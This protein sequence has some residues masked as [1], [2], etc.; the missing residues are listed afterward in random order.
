MPFLSSHLEMQLM[1]PPRSSC[2][3]QLRRALAVGSLFLGLAASASAQGTDSCTT[4]QVVAGFGSFAFDNSAAAAGNDFVPA[5]APIGRDVWFTWTAASSGSTTVATCGG[6]GLDSVMAVYNGNT[7]PGAAELACSDDACGAQSSVTF[8]ATSGNSYVIQI[9]SY[10]TGA[11]STGTFTISGPPVP[12]VNDDCSAATAISGTGLFPF[13]TINATTGAQGQT[14]SLCLA[15]GFNAIAKDVWYNWTAPSTGIATVALCGQTSLDSKI[16]SYLGAGCPSA[17]ALACNDD[18]CSLQS[19]IQFACTA[20]QVYALQIGSYPGGSGSSGS[21]NFNITVGAPMVKLSQIYGA[22]GN[23]QSPVFN[24]YI[25][26][27]NAGP[28]AQP[29]SGWSVQYASAA[30]AFTALNTTNLPAVN[31]APGQYLLVNEATGATLVAGQTPNNPLGDASGA[32]AMSGTDMKVALVSSTAFIPTALGQPTYAAVPTLVDF[33]GCGTANWNDTAAA[34]GT[35]VATNNA[36]AITTAAASYRQTCGLTDTNSSIADWS[37]GFPAPR[38][39]ATVANTGLGV[40]GSALPLTPKAGQTVRLTATPF[41]CTTNDLAAGTTM[42]A[43]LTLI[44]GS[45]T[46]AMVDDGTGGDEVSNDGL[47]TA[48]VTVGAA[49]PTGTVNLPIKATNGASVG[50]SYISLFIEPVATP[51]NDNC[52]GAQALTINTP[53][54]GTCVGATV[55]T[56]PIVTGVT[57]GA[58]TSGMSSR[59]G[60]WYSVV[61]TGNSMSASL[62]GTLPVFDSVMIVMTGSC[63]GLTVIGVD[64]DFCA[65]L[66]ASQVTWCSQLGA[67]YYIWVAPFSTALP[68]NTFTIAVNDSGTACTGAFP[69]TLC[70]GVSGPFTE[71]EAMY[72]AA[73]NE[74]CFTNAAKFTDIPMPG[75]SATILRGTAR[76]LINTRDVDCYRFQATGS[77]PIQITIDTLGSQAQAQLVS[78]GA[79]GTCPS[80]AI[81]NTPI[82]LTRC[83]TGIQTVSANVVSGTWYAI[84][85]IGGIDIQ[86]TPAGTIFGGEMPGGTTIQYTLSVN[87]G[88][89]P[90][91]DLCANATTLSGVSVA[92]N[93]LTATNDGSSPCDASGRDVWYTVTN[94][95][96]AGFLNLDTCGSTGIDTVISVYDSC[97]GLLLGCNDDCGGTPCGATNSC[98]SVAIAAGQTLKIRVS[99]KGLVGGAFTLNWALVVPPPANDECAT[100]TVISGNGPFAYDN[101]F[102]TPTTA[103]APTSTCQTSQSK[104]IWYRWTSAGAGTVNVDTCGGPTWDSVI[105]IYTGSCGTL[106]EIACDDDTCVTPAL[107]SSLSFTAACTTTYYIRISSFGTSIGVTG[108]FNLTAPGNTDTDM[109]GTPDCIDGC[110]LDPAKIAPGICGCGVSDADTDGDGTVDCLDGCPNDANKIA[111]GI[112]GCGVSDVDTDGDGTADCLDGCPND[113]NKIAPGICGCGVSDVDT[114]GDGTADCLDGCPNDPAK[115]APG[116]CGCGVSDV[117][118]DGDGTADCFDGCPN[119]ANKIAPGQCGCGNLDTD[120]DGDGTADCNDGCPN[121]SAKTAPGQCGCGVA[122]TDSDGDGVANCIDNC[123]TVANASQAD[124]DNDG[125]GDACDNCVNISNPAQGDCDADNIGDAC[126]IASGAPDCNMNG[127]PDSCDIASATSQDANTNGIPDECEL[128]GGTPFCFG[129]SGCP[130]GNN[131][132]PGMGQGCMNST[133]QGAKLLGS[134][135]TQ[136][137]NDNLVLTCTQLPIPGVPPGFVQFFQGTASTSIPFNDGKRCVTGTLVRLATKAHATGASS[138]P[139]LGDL[140]IHQKGFVPPAGGVRYYQAWYRNAIGP[141]GTGSNLSNGVSVIWAP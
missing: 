18:T 139:Q 92:G 44:G 66:N 83:A 37:N 71:K 58:F 61:G 103:T 138:Y 125:V 94:G 47:Y 70:T 69:V 38:N 67:T 59:K 78:L 76:G 111:P 12:P 16:A 74:G 105:T 114:D 40:I 13:T 96:D 82:F 17:S 81:A 25:E 64:D 137:S 46:Q 101:R 10:N 20:G 129:D 53:T 141:C 97:G 52:Y 30:G 112:C 72:G 26:I 126:E 136:V 35:N 63:D 5:C 106:T 6:T 102:A 80:T 75:S 132:I 43:D 4:P 14:E 60:V 8:T 113:S 79:G 120:T 108:T 42:L 128:N 49:T 84:N 23:S 15:F 73:Q 87:V 36:P 34:G 54:A 41:R 28:V 55:E 134:G 122:D 98:L 131:S 7:C 100:A 95:P 133:G 116:I 140:P 21:G 51:D 119:D 99:D 27:Y 9:G 45:A 107:G 3:S 48:L 56:N 93:T 39:T 85:V 62:C 65:S 110:P 117:D 121:D 31:L 109:D 68:T 29:L 123:V 2:T 22:G 19:Q 90:A 24:D 33:F 118:T 89:P 32:I 11:G 86:A 130:C 115:I 88:A 135:L 104:D 124:L 91:N 57:G 1:A 77:G 50:G 127:I